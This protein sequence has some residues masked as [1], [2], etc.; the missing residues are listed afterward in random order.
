[1]PSG[2]TGNRTVWTNK[3]TGQVR[4]TT[5]SCSITASSTSVSVGQSVTFSV[6]VS[7]P[8]QGWT[9]YVNG[10]PVG[11]QPCYGVTCPPQ[12]YTFNTA[13]TYTV[14]GQVNLVGGGTCRTNQVTVTVSGRT[15]PPPQ[16]TLTV[17]PAAPWSVGQTV[18]ATVTVNVP[19][20]GW[21]LYVNGNP[22]GSQPCYGTA[23]PPQRYTIPASAAGTT[24]TF[25]GLVVLAY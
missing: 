18:T 3:V 17:T 1:M 14:Y 13:G 11:S 16:A 20:T 12:S 22:V 2:G 4:G 24:M 21:T 10:N 7:G 6:T 15:T 5:A 25:Q 8:A 23:C 9:L 19:A